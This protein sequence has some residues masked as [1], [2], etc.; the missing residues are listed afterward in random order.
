M[1][2]TIALLFAISAIL[3]V[4]SCGPVIVSHR[5]SDPPPP[6]FYPNR[7]ETVRYVYFP[8]HLVYYDLSLR[9]YL[10]L[11]GGVWVS[12]NVLPRRFNNINLRRSRYIRIR[13]YHGDDIKRYH[14]ENHLNRGRSN[15]S[16][17]LKRSNDRRRTN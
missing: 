16:N 9:T 4:S 14:Q 8:E 1:K 11:E 2:N 13:D 15:K 7:I 12:V 10:Y 6:W 17:R 5:L 3:C